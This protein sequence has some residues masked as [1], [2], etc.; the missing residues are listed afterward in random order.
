MKKVI[1]F[2]KKMFSKSEQKENVVE[3]KT[4][5]PIVEEVKTTVTSEVKKEDVKKEE[6]KK[7]EIKSAEKKVTAKEIKS[8]ARKPQ[9][10]EQK[11]PAANPAPKT[12]V[13]KSKSNNNSNKKQNPKKKE[14]Q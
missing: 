9:T 5:C 14:G 13:K 4:D 10:S 3:N 2:F 8:K 12:D 11:K 7:E 6:V 1:S